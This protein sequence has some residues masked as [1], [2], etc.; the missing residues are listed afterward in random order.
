MR[1]A[2]FMRWICL[3]LVFLDDPVPGVEHDAQ[4]VPRQKWREGLGRFEFEKVAVDVRDLDGRGEAFR[5]DHPAK[6][7]IERPACVI[8]RDGSL[9]D[10]RQ[11][12]LEAVGAVLVIV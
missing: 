10:Q 12:R 7:E 3:R 9:I 5:K 1:N 2:A 8:H 4:A 11:R 6:I